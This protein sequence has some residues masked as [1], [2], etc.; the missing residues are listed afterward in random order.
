MNQAY[1]M[2]VE[3]D[4]HF[5]RYGTVE[6]QAIAAAHLAIKFYDELKQAEAAD[7]NNSPE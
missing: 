3:L 6:G 1:T 4:E 5:Q 2:V 7:S